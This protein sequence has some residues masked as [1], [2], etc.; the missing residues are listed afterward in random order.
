MSYIHLWSAGVGG[1]KNLIKLTLPWLPAW[2]WEHGGAEGS[3]DWALG[4]L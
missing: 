2:R 4:M 1:Y 3:G